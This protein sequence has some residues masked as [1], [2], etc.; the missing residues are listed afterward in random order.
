[1][2]PLPESL[3]A[4]KP[5]MPEM[6]VPTRQACQ[7][8]S[9]WTPLHRAQGEVHDMAL[10]QFL[11]ETGQHQSAHFS[12]KQQL[13]APCICSVACFCGQGIQINLSPM[14]NP[15]IRKLA[16]HDQIAQVTQDLFPRQVLLP[17]STHLYLPKVR[18]TSAI[19]YLIKALHRS[20]RLWNSY[21]E[22]NCLRSGHSTS[23]GRN[24]PLTRTQSSIQTTSA[25]WISIPILI[26]KS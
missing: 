25:F 16:G 17:C 2:G 10:L 24:P 4:S 21:C 18:G 13:F 5:Q 26:Y 23:P 15:E 20:L 7:I 1:M 8:L 3:Q 22:L 9:F 11:G 19:F 6:G 12:H 14:T